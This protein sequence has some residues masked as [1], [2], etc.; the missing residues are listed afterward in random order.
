MARIE[1]FTMAELA[2][3]TVREPRDRQNGSELRARCPGHWDTI[4]SIAVK[5]EASSRHACRRLAQWKSN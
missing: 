5:P 2:H 4:H 3:S 1:A